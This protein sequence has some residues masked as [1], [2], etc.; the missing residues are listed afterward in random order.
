MK[1]SLFERP[2][3]RIAWALAAGLT[4]ILGACG[5]T[6]PLYQPP[7][8]ATGESARAA[9]AAVSARADRADVAGS[10]TSDQAP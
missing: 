2:T 7:E 4:A 1:P 6:G 3:P 8:P 10:S 9:G 5:Q